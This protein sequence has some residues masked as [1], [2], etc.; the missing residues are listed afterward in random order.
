MC[1]PDDSNKDMQGASPEPVKSRSSK[2][3]AGLDAVGNI[4]DGAK[5]APHHLGAFFFLTLSFAWR[6]KSSRVFICT[7][8]RKEL[9]TGS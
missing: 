8:K 5:A 7:F 3:G 9:G 4:A 6:K 2:N 1:N